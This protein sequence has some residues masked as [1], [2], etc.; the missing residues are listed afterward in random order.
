MADE[1]LLA[2]FVSPVYAAVILCAP[3]VKELVVE[4]AVPALSVPVPKRLPPFRN[5]TVPV[6]VLGETVAV[7]RTACP[8]VD[9]LLLELTAVVVLFCTAREVEPLTEFTVAVIVVVPAAAPVASP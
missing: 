8:N 5:C 3:A 1:V 9:G 6:A 7:N 4:L 2:S